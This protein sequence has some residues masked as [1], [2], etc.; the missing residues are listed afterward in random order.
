MAEYIGRGAEFKRRV[1]G[2]RARPYRAA[3]S[4]A[5]LE[6]RQR[7]L[8]DMLDSLGIATETHRHRPVFTVEESRNLRGALPGAHF[9]S[10]F[11]KDKKGAFWLVVAMEDR[12]LDLKALAPLIGAARLSFGSAGRLAEQLGVAPG[13]V[14][15]FALIDDPD[16]AVRLVIDAAMMEAELANF[17]PLSND[18][19][20]A[21][22]PADLLR[23]AEA[24]GHAPS[25]TDLGPATVPG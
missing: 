17:H 22:V 7:A 1:A 5:D 14:T 3:M 20:T 12:K 25:V 4:E 8:F 11:F 21:I 13:A 24:T 15:P 16:G 10:L 19:T 6:R 9:K 18:A 2:H 23:F